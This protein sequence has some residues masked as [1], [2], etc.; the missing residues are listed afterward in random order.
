MFLAVDSF[1]SP[2]TQ[3]DLLL[4]ALP[5]RRFFPE[6]VPADF[7][8]AHSIDGT[9]PPERLVFVL[10]QAVVTVNQELREFRLKYEAI[11][12]EHLSELETDRLSGSEYVFLYVRAVYAF[13]HA[14]LLQRLLNF[15]ATAAAV[16]ESETMR[17]TIGDYLQM[18]RFAISDI[19]GEPRFR[20]TAI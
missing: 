19:L 13:A 4:N 10:S 14:E 7:V 18:A 1:R 20:A 11:G 5:R 12:C 3:N 16:K 15:D 9:I 6:I 2:V 8:A 17:E